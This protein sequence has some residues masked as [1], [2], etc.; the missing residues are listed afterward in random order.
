M[1][2]V[3]ARWIVTMHYDG[4]VR[5]LAKIPRPPRMIE[6]HL[7]VKLFK[8]RAHDRGRTAA[9]AEAPA[10]KGDRPSLGEKKPTRSSVMLSETKHLSS[11]IVVSPIKLIRDS[12]LRSE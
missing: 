5:Q 9:F 6:D 2:F 12:S 8:F 11:R 3:S 4:S 7:L 10:P 1:N